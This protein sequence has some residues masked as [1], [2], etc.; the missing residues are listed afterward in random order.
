MTANKPSILLLGG[1]PDAEREVSLT[2]HRAAS[3][4]LRTLGYTVNAQVIDR[5]DAREIKAM[6]GDV[7]FPLLHGPYGEGGPLQDLLEQDGR[8]YIGCQ[9]RAARLAMDKIATKA[10]A[11]QCG[12]P[13]APCAVLNLRD[14]TC[15]FDFPVVAK[16]IHEGSSVG[17]HICRSQKDW[18][19]ALVAIRAD[20]KE[21]PTRAYMVEQFIKARELTQGLLD[22]SP[23]TGAPGPRLGIV[24]IKPAVEFYDYHAKYHS[25]DTKYQV[26]PPLPSGVA[27][28]VHGYAL[29]MA[30]Q[31]GI[32]HLSRIDFLLDEHDRPWLLEVNT[33]PGFTGHSLLPMAAADSGI[34]FASLCEKLVQWAVRDRLPA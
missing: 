21:H 34:S 11:L 24:E 26:N 33:L 3:D 19:A 22:P 30:R 23:R 12:V 27:D 8:P 2:G 17:V 9:P 13:T 15:P 7:V 16:P 6:P 18:A 31:L 1:G 32:R 5:P 4:A 29:T 25:D 20:V 10:I 28:A 14:S